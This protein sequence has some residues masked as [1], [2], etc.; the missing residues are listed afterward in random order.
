[1]N[2]KYPID[3]VKGKYEKDGY[4]VLSEFAYGGR[5]IDAIALSPWEARKYGLHL[6]EVKSF[7]ED[8]LRELHNP[9][10]QNG[11]WN[12][13][14]DYWFLETEEGIIKPEEVPEGFGLMRWREGKSLKIV[15]EAE[16]K[17][18]NYDTDFLMAFV[19]KM[20]KYY[21]AE[22]VSEAYRRG[23]EEGEESSKQHIDILRNRIVEM[24]TKVNKF[25]DITGVNLWHDDVQEQAEAFNAFNRAKDEN[26]SSL[27]N[28]IENRIATL[29][30]CKKELDDFK[31]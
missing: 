1:M 16:Y 13:G 17:P 5:R 27:I 25:R 15:K 9:E 4:I 19:N 29:R 2:M 24:E 6:F 18:P 10:K 21:N 12:V 26:F 8:W 30:K 14:G 11:F 20:R 3:A 31:G 22:K 23:Y 7:R 28:N